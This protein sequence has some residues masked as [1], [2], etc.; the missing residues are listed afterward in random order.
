MQSPYSISSDD[1]GYFFATDLNV[2]YRIIFENLDQI[3]KQY[4]SLQGRVFSF[5]FYPISINRKT[6]IKADPRVKGT[7]ALAISN[8]FRKH[9]N[10]IAFVCDS[11]DKR[12][13]GRKKLFDKWFNDLNKLNELEK[14]D[15][16]VHNGDF[17]IINTIILRSD[18][19]DKPSILEIF[20][21]LNDEFSRAK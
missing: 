1:Q 3:F 7:I 15:G 19:A 16:K 12:E 6:K 9:S 2:T 10:L 8:F 5:S 21:A 4:P 17:E 20:V 11:T 18:L 14:Y 13:A